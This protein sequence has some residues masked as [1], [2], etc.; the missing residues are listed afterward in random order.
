MVSNIECLTIFISLIFLPPTPQSKR[1]CCIR[2]PLVAK[3]LEVDI[4]Q[5]D[6]KKIQSLVYMWSKLTLIF[7]NVGALLLEIQ[8]FF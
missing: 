3:F 6:G 4:T 8:T 1:E 5:L 2:L 7:S